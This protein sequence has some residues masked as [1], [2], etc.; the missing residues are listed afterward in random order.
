MSV[1]PLRT[2]KTVNEGDSKPPLKTDHRPWPLS[3]EPVTL[4]FVIELVRV[5]YRLRFL[6]RHWEAPLALPCALY[7][8]L[9]R[10]SLAP[11]G[12]PR[13]SGPRGPDCTCL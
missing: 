13:W 11:F 5:R 8:P 9:S 1:I 4:C 2:T 3:L 7:A 6:G 10:S 12:W